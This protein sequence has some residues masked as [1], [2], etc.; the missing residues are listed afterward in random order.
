MESAPLPPS[1]GAPV[2]S[3]RGWRTRR[4][5]GR[6]S[7]RSRLLS[8]FG[9]AVGERE[10]ERGALLLTAEELPSALRFRLPSFLGWCPFSTL[11]GSLGRPLT[12]EGS[13]RESNR[14]SSTVF[15]VASVIAKYQGGE[16]SI[17]GKR[18][19]VLTCAQ[20]VLDDII[21]GFA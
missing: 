10:S 19:S 18:K 7:G 13:E 12:A 20:H 3:L 1:E 17:G 21:V 5:G 14:E 11:I 15:G 4:E 9:D 2:G 16:R 8:P 6:P